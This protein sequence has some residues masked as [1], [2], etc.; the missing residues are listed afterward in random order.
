V[1]LGPVPP[2]APAEVAG[3][4]FDE[5]RIRSRVAEMGAEIGADYAG[6]EP[7][8]VTV[9]RGGLFFLA[10]LC[11]E[12]PIDM[13]LDFMSISSY[14]SVAHDGA[15]AVRVTK[16]LDEDIEGAHVLVVEDVIDTGLTLNYLLRALRARRPAS[17]EVAVLLDRDQRRIADLPISYR[18]F[19]MPDTFVVGYGLDLDGRYRNLPYIGALADDVLASRG[20]S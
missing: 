11:R 7:V 12:I 9:L 18:G 3:V 13:R 5:D 20:V 10:D 16:D 15:G 1:R 6:R 14:G 8:L 4:L 17:L 19:H 2:G